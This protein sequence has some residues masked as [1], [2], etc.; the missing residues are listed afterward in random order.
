MPAPDN[1]P[2]KALAHT[3][4]LRGD[5]DEAIIELDSALELVPTDAGAYVLRGTCHLGKSAWDAAI[6]DFTRSLA[7]DLNPLARSLAYMHRGRARGAKNDDRMAVADCN[8]ALRLNPD[9]ADAYVLRGKLRRRAL[10]REGAVADFT[11]ALK[12]NPANT[13]T[14]LQ[15]AQVFAEL[16][17]VE[18]AKADYAAAVDLDA[19]LAEKVPI[20]FRKHAPP[21]L[22]TNRIEEARRSLRAIG[23]LAQMDQMTPAA[24]AS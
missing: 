21:N 1:F 14:L 24:K 12:L 10:E 18:K 5:F 13:E 15:R 9:N 19:T 2:L 22:D 3:Q 17:S 6:A 8:E 11:E 7:G 20:H 4:M 16:G 23:F